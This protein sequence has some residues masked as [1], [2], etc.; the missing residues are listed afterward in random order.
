MTGY[1]LVHDVTEELRKLRRELELLKDRNALLEE[2]ADEKWG[3]ADAATKELVNRLADLF[4]VAVR[5]R[6][7]ARLEVERLRDVILR[8]IPQKTE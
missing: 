5:E 8:S 4:E 1:Q 6:D 3:A 7:L 2:I